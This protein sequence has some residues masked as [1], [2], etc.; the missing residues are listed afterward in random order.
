MMRWRT[1][2]WNHPLCTTTAAAAT[3]ISAATRKP[4]KILTTTLIQKSTSF[5]SWLAVL[6]PV[7]GPSHLQPVVQ[8]FHGALS[9]QQILDLRAALFKRGDARAAACAPSRGQLLVIVS[10][11]GVRNLNLRPEA[12]LGE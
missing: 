8:R 3:A 7:R 9:R 11:V 12:Q 2:S 6:N 4:A 10:Q 5:E 1:Y